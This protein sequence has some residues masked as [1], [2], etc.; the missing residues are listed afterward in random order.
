M[1]QFS[2]DPLCIHP[3]IF[4]AFEN[5][6]EYSSYS[7]RDTTAYRDISFKIFKELGLQ[8]LCQ[9]KLVCK[10][11]KYLIEGGSLAIK[12]YTLA[13]KLFIQKGNTIKEAFC[14]ER[15]GDIYLGKDSTK[16]LLQAVGLYNYSLRISSED[17][18]KIIKEKLFNA[19]RLLTRICGGKP[20][21]NELI[22][23]QFEGNREVL[24]NFREV[25]EKEIQVL[26]ENPSPQEVRKLYRDIAKDVKSF[27]SI[28]TNQ[29]IDV[30]GDAP[31]EYAMIGF[32]SLAR[33]EMTPYSDLE[34]GVLIQ[35][36][37]LIN[38]KYF[39]DFTNLLHLQV[40]NLGETIL[41]ALNIPC[42]KAI[43]FFDGIT[44]RGFAFD[45][46]G[47]E[48][49]GCKTPLGN[50]KTFELIQT[51]EKMAQYIAQDEN[52]EWWHEKEPHLPMELLT[53]T[54]LL[55][56]EE[57]T[58]QYRQSVQHKLATP[59]QQD[60]DLRQY[61]A[62]KHLIQADM[63]SFNPNL[64]DLRRQG[65]LF[66]AKEDFYRFP[67]LALDRLALFIKVTA[68]NTFS[69]L[70]QLN[71]QGILTDEAAEK[72]E[73]W[74]SIAL[75]MRLRTY[76]YYQSQK[77]MMNPLIKLFGF[78]DPA[79]I[80]KQFALN[81]KLLK[82]VERIYSIFIPFYQAVQK[83]LSGDEE[84]LKSSTLNGD[85]PQIQGDIALRLFQQE[86]AKKWYI[87]ARQSTPQNPDIINILG[88]IYEEQGDL[89][90]AA[91]CINQAIATECEHAEKDYFKMAKFYNNLAQ[92]YTQ[93]GKLEQAEEFVKK[94]LAIGLK[95]KKGNLGIVAMSCNKLSQINLA[96][97]SLELA[98]EYTNTAL[99]IHLNFLGRDHP[100]VAV[101]YNNLGVFYTEQKN[102]ALAEI[103]TMKALNI[104]I[105]HYGENHPAVARDYNN[106]AWVYL[107]LKKLEKADEY[108]K[109]ALNINLKLFGDNHPTG[110][111]YYHTQGV[112]YKN[113]RNMS[114]AAEYCEKALEMQ[115]RLSGEKNL[116]VAIIYTNLGAIYKE[117]GKSKQAVERTKKALFII[118][119]L[120][121]RK[122]PNGIKIYYSLAE[123]Y[124]SQNELRL[125]GKYIKKALKIEI[126]LLD[127]NDY[128]LA[129]FYHLL[130]QVYGK[131]GK[132]GRAAEHA[133]KALEIKIMHSGEN[134][135]EVAKDYDKLGMLYLKHG[136]LELAAKCFKKEIKINTLLFDENHHKLSILHYQLGQIYIKQRNLDQAAEHMKKALEIKI[137]HSGENHYKVAILY[138]NL[139]AIYLALEK[140]ELAIQYAEKAINI[141]TA[142]L[143]K[144]KHFSIV[145]MFSALRKLYRMPEKIGI[146]S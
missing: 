68:S 106:L 28:L 42:L 94:A 36:D 97:R 74:M 83:F 35:E 54:H 111:A 107:G 14:I 141:K 89:K 60:F 115:L 9:A 11:W 73:E 34:F 134:N 131:Q 25:I 133:K 12:A 46:A 56:N 44:P 84:A 82:K 22:E 32:G 139:G 145:M 57:L 122:H 10:E 81:P 121:G 21:S 135:L 100:A 90:T 77:E 40:I 125:A 51:P 93:Q 79:L 19:Q 69:R 18:Q 103:Y 92:I 91:D 50:G 120:F 24:K 38:K 137:M 6:E 23:K 53:F 43:H 114:Q 109:R 66:R 80:R 61:L 30:L 130:G 96:R 138:N 1:N 37:T 119:G 123:I 136:N 95:P 47:V 62:K 29:A 144:E 98:I 116:N 75:L 52:G 3:L 117:Q 49:K 129:N 65:M 143:F 99:V 128:R 39:R 27:F 76:S 88:L 85:L 108:S 26:S 15:L 16:A 110:A 8:D 5:K 48:G 59:Y 71:E 7:T 113:Q 127:K 13:L 63:I 31:C 132:L 124:I 17:Q 45:G 67:H 87:L 101:E 86:E 118:H 112:I 33:E 58:E 102:F 126:P 72:L 20:L 41:P 142:L 104:D 140:L 78:E 2:S 64:N 55:G 146:G 4:P 70:A 105:K